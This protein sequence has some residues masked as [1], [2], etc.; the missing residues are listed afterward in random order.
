MEECNIITL[1]L[2]ENYI[3]E[4]LEVIRTLADTEVAIKSGVPII[5]T[6]QPFIITSENILKG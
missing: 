1:Y 2:S 4:G 3:P 6:T 5:N